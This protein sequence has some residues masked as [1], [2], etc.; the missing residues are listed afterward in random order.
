MRL[1]RQQQEAE[2]TDRSL[3]IEVGNG[4]LVVD[5]G[6]I[7]LSRDVMMDPLR[8]REEFH[9]QL[10]ELANMFDDLD[11]ECGP[12]GGSELQDDCQAIRELTR[13]EMHPRFQ[14]AFHQQQTEILDTQILAG[15]VAGPDAK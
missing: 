9:I 4:S 5:L 11:H 13:K 8:L 12:M 10:I 6:K 15:L 1:G 3:G 7:T 14:E 2:T